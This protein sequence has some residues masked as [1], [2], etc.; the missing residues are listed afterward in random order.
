MKIRIMGTMDE[1][2]QARAF[3]GRLA[4]N[5]DVKYCTISE[6]YSNR[7][8]VGYYRVYID[9]D[10]KDGSNIF[11]DLPSLRSEEDETIYPAC[12]DDIASF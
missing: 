1:C 11:S 10:Y 6:P 9:I 2:K 5:S 3:Y 12:G 7:G 4:L 8:S